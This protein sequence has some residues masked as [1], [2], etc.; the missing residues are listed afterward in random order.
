MK[1]EFFLNLVFLIFVNL[2][3]KPFYIF[4]IDRT[5]QN[6]VI[7]GDYG[8]YFML[9]NF[10]M[11]FQIINDFGIQQFNTR[12]IA[13]HRHLLEK[14]FPNILILKLGLSFFYTIIIS[15]FAYVLGYLPEY[16]HLFY[17]F[18][19]NQILISLI[20][21][22]R[23]NIV[24]LGH[25]RLDSIVSILDRLLLIIICS[26]L[27]WGNLFTTTFQIEWFVY[28]QSISLGT[29]TLIAFGMI[30]FKLQFLHFH[31]NKSF[32]ISLLR[33][34]YPYAIMVFLMTAYTRL[35]SIM[36]DQLLENGATENDVY[37]A[38]Y[39]ILDAANM[40]AFLFASLLLPMFANLLVHKREEISSLVEF[41]MGLM[42][43][44]TI[45]VVIAIFC[46]R[47]EIMDLLYTR[48]NEYWGS[49]MGLLILNFAAMGITYVY[50]TLLTANNNIRQMN[51]IFLVGCVI[52]F[53]F[54]FIL[55]PYY[56][57]IGAA[58]A[59]LIT[60]FLMAIAQLILCHKKINL[61]IPST[62]FIKIGGFIVLSVGISF[63]FLQ[64]NLSFWYVNF[65]LLIM[66][67]FTLSFVLKIVSI[68][69][70]FQLLSKRPH[71]N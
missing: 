1:K 67:L 62:L 10:T 8:I 22:F 61:P 15:G 13:Q 2:L 31:W 50:G 42:M 63:L 32:L 53:V 70:I 69:S 36:I 37:A 30:Y 17:F 33:Q 59:T 20:G 46:Y 51:R 24:G 29:T 38:A 43:S 64:L 6:T 52:N 25:Y 55:I 35:D 71:I 45:P 3:I 21:F 58:I 49:L 39:R 9:F 4:G 66:L 27:L 65:I 19:L 54:N 12:N 48:S 23:S 7:E 40:I 5:I 47:M 57:A 44:I 34:S 18:V 11:L 28:A 26:L 56:S 41:S 68:Q 60:Q 16:I 14:Y